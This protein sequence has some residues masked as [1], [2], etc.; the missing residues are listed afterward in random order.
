MCVMRDYNNVDNNKKIKPF[1]DGTIEFRKIWL[2]GD[3]VWQ[4]VKDTIH[5]HN[6]NNIRRRML[7][8]KHGASST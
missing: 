6:E 1:V 5:D 2:I 3:G 4:S 8:R 7:Y